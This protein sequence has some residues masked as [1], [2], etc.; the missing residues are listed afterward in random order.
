MDKIN[1][2]AFEPIDEEERELMESIENDEWRS[3]KNFKKEKENCN[4]Y[5]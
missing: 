1:K 5:R 2:K 4:Y 3:I